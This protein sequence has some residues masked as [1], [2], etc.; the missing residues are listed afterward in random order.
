MAPLARPE[1]SIGGTSIGGGG[2]TMPMP[3]TR[4]DR[5]TLSAG[6][7]ATTVAKETSKNTLF[8]FINANFIREFGFGL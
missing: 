1:S 8:I 4:L 7:A 5:P 3:N 6:T 2:G